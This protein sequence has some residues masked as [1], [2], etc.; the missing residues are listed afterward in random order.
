VSSVNKS[1]RMH[2]L[3]GCMVATLSMAFAGAS[4]AALIPVGTGDANVVGSSPP[5]VGCCGS[6]DEDNIVNGSGFGVSG[7]KLIVNTGQPNDN[8][9]N[10]ET[11]TA[12]ITFDLGAVYNIDFIQ[13]WNFNDSFGNNDFGPETIDLLVSNVGTNA[14][15]A[16]FSASSV[17]VTLPIAHATGSLIYFGENYRFNGK[18]ASD[19]P[20]E[21]GGVL[22]DYSGVAV[23]GRFV[24][25]ADLDGSLS[26]G[27]RTGLSEV[28]FFGSPV[29]EPSTL[30]LMGVYLA[31]LGFTQRKT[32]A[33]R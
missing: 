1:T 25:F 8:N 14:Q 24:R 2:F 33:R 4:W 31:G 15:D 21:L 16:D 3:A 32:K 10:T 5:E 11:A 12:D 7:G 6:R 30:L 9:W 19:I 13:I 26:F 23:Q 27:G 28:R 22:H 18:A 17:L 20:S 29:P